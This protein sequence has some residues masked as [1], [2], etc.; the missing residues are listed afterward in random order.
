MSSST[1]LVCATQRSGSTLLCKALSATGVAGRPEEYFE[2]LEATGLPA[3]PRDYLPVLG[4]ELALPPLRH[5]DPL[6]PFAERLEA[7]R[8][9]GTTPNGVFGAKVMWSYGAPVLAALGSD[10]GVRWVLVRRRDKLRQ[11]I[12][13]WR[14]IQTRQWNADD[15]AGGEAAYSRAAIDALRERLAGEE[16]AWERW[17]AGRD[18]LVLDYD[19][20]ASQPGDAVAA[21]LRHIGVEAPADLTGA[22]PLRR[23]ADALTED[24]VRRHAA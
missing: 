6:P 11:A 12:S 17:L 8:R 4:D 19:D 7:A 3:Q 16:A 21:V 15:A 10:P 20:F 1:Y 18:P 23:Q 2:A 9:A 5:G 14:A 24:W 13:L 22:A